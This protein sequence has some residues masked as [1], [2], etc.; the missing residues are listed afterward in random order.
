MSVHFAFASVRLRSFHQGKTFVWVSVATRLCITKY[1]MQKRLDSSP[2]T[3]LDGVESKQLISLGKPFQIRLYFVQSS[4][5]DIPLGT[6]EI[7]MVHGR[8]AAARKGEKSNML[9]TDDDMKSK[10][11]CASR[12]IRTNRRC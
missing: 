3:Y 9:R 2:E 6:L 4:N 11:W 5:G 8:S 10:L 7:D 1:H 12:N